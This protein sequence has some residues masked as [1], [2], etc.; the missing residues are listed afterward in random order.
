MSAI[1]AI[2]AL[3]ACM[4]TFECV[5]QVPGVP[6]ANTNVLVRVALLSDSHLNF[7]TSGDQTNYQARFEATVA[8]VNAANVGFVLI[9]GDLSQSGTLRE[10]A[11]FKQQIQKFHEPVWFV[12]GNHDTGD[13]FNS[14]KTTHVTPDRIKTYEHTVGPSW[15]ATNCAGVRIIGI[16]SSI[17]G[18]GF[19]VE[20]QMWTFLEQELGAPARVPTILFMHY[21]LFLHDLD[22]PGGK[23]WNVEPAP[24]ERLYAL[25]QQGGVK[26]VLTGH[27]HRPLVNRRNG[28]R[29]ITT[30]PTSFGIPAGKQ[31]EG[32]TLV[33]ILKNGEA[34]EEF[35]TSAPPT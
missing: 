3:V 17:L 23:Y 20:K 11:E 30:P 25:L 2:P 33:T 28:I 10:Y 6:E 5:G 19:E 21:P 18:S 34:T 29:F 16:N 13:K 8:Q 12:P 4:F 9:A 15:F 22:E 1:G 35:E 27:L 24:R 7:A 32:W 14:G 26:I 31:P